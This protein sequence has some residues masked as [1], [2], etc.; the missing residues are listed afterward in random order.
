[1]NT[2]SLDW[3]RVKALFA[4][5]QELPAPQRESWLRAQ[6]EEDELFAEVLS[7]L[8]AQQ[9]PTDA[10]RQAAGARLLA[11]LLAAA[12][13]E[14]IGERV[15]AYRLVELIGEGGMGC[16]YLAERVDGSFGQRV[17]LK[18]IRP[19]F[20]THEL[21]ERFLREREILARLHHPHIAQLH[22]GGVTGDGA[23]YFTLEY[24]AG[25]PITRWC[26][27]RAV[28]LRGRVSLLL[29][30]CDAVQY[31][32]R[33]LIVHRDLKPANILVDGDG[34][35]KLL[36]F[37]IAKLL[38]PVAAPGL[39]GTQAQPMTREY[40]A[41]EQVLGE[42][43]TT[44]TDVYAL[45]VLLYE[46][47]CGHLPYANAERGTSSWAKAIVEE[48]AEAPARALSRDTDP[49]LEGA[50]VAAMRGVGLPLLRRSLRGDVER[51]ARRALE[52]A[53]EARY[54]SV[55]AFA[56]DLRAW[57]EGRALPGGNR[58]Y[59]LRKFVRRN[60]MAVGLG[61]L[62][63]GSVIAGLVSVALQQRRIAAEA[64]L[65]R[66]EAQTA[67]AVKDFLIGLL[68]AGSP[69]EAKGKD[70]GVRELIDRGAVRVEQGLAEQ[71]ALK[72]ELQSVL[73]RIYFQLGSYAQAQALQQDALAT[74][75]DDPGQSAGTTMRQLAETLAARGDYAAAESKASDAEAALAGASATERIGAAIAHAAIVQ[76]RGQ[77]QRARTLAMAAVAQARAPGVPR[78]L[79][80][81]ALN[82]LGLVQWDLRDVA[83]VET[84]Y[85]EALSIHRELYGENDL[86]VATDRQNLTLALR[87]LGRYDEALEQAQANVAIRENI[88]GPVH[89][90]LVRALSTLGTTLYH[91]GRYAE[92][93]PILRRS[94]AL[95]RAVFGADHPG[96]ATALN[97]LG[98]VL[99]D[100]HGLDEAEEIYTQIVRIDTAQ[101]GA[102]HNSTL[103]AASNL[104]YVHGQ[105]GKLELAER[106]LRDALA[107]D[108]TARIADEV[109]EL[110]RLGDVRR[111]RGDWREAI[112]LHRQA[113]QRALTLFGPNTRQAGWSHYFLGLALADGGDRDAAIAE[114]DA[115][116]DV[117]RKLLP[118]DGAH[119]ASASARLALGELLAQSE[120]T[121]ARGLDLLRQ[122]IDL[123]TRF[124]GADDARTHAARQSLAKLQVSR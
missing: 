22:D 59:R 14:R 19:E 16:V 9:Q 96:T 105:Q 64:R 79:L 51:I 74:L 1:M 83:Q 98:L 81:D 63:I 60:R 92:A 15:G 95:A 8:Q 27:A 40:A 34:V 99:M 102:N 124:L 111:R 87:N 86:R 62:L 66:H 103:T 23:P 104:G 25:E 93:E 121:R 90:D 109:W 73:G 115:A 38:D 33:N 28:G 55:T 106:E 61:V 112:D 77:S 114:L 117:W 123:R 48:N 39:T 94:V 7:L 67:A 97:N 53:P 118:P 84:T 119:P 45:G 4:D 110:N 36:D 29:Q 107:R 2:T 71:P 78:E 42:P 44:A 69:D 116:V 52:K 47:L 24:V 43:I 85:R 54:A 21:R 41:P 11:P 113:L 58:R 20:A 46:L 49:A 80:G 3:M 82:T 100:W 35:P 91:M 50:A 37:G 108:R 17:A 56:A 5:A 6:C 68:R 70:V 75:G 88:L 57:L 18:L 10:L 31:A 65:A 101:L 76:Q 72:A 13:H 89:P 32:H 30:V 26:D 122:A 12:D 120:A